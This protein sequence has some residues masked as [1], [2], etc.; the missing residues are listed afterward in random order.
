MTT[1]GRAPQTQPK[2]G[3]TASIPSYPLRN[4]TSVVAR[5]LVPPKP[6]YVAKDIDIWQE[7]ARYGTAMGQ[8]FAYSLPDMSGVHQPRMY[9]LSATERYSAG[10]AICSAAATR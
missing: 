6:T 3:T 1:T 4:A 2:A 9:F 7:K 5:V 10:A 8:I